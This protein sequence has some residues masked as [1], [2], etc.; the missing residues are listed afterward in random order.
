MKL[1]K[2]EKTIL[3]SLKKHWKWMARDK[4]GGFWVYNKKPIKHSTIW[5]IEDGYTFNSRDLSYLF[6][7][8]LF[9]F[10]TWEDEEPTSIDELLENC[11]VQDA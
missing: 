5:N 8:K 6:K 1:T 4:N 11:E 9:S 2:A 10:I 7:D 3:K